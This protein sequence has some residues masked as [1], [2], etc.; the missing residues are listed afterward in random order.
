MVGDVKWQRNLHGVNNPSHVR[1]LW[2]GGTIAIF[3]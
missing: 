1:L 2:A 3:V